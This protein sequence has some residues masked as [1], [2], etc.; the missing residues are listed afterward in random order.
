MS[1]VLYPKPEHQR[2][3]KAKLSKPS[4]PPKYYVQYYDPDNPTAFQ[5]VA[6][7]NSELEV[8]VASWWRCKVLGFQRGATL[9]T[10]K[11]YKKLQ[12]QTKELEG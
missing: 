6:Q 4:K 7:Y 12:E 5:E 2:P 8:K 1:K 9:F 10:R 11:E 3:K